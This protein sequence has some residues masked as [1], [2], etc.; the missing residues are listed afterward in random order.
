M[1]VK[2]ICNEVLAK[3]YDYHANSGVAALNAVIAKIEDGDRL[4]QVMGYIDD[5]SRDYAQHYNNE[6]VGALSSLRDELSAER[7]DI[8]E[9]HSNVNSIITKYVYKAIM[10]DESFEFKDNVT[11]VFDL[12]FLHNS[13]ITKKQEFLYLL[14]DLSDDYSDDVDSEL[15]QQVIT[16]LKDEL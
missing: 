8:S 2:V 11:K 13:A 6:A 1:D 9:I 16:D 4:G 3:Y 5:V 12:F 10:N 7:V 14:D 15:I